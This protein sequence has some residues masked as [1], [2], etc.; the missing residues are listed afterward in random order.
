MHHTFLFSSEGVCPSDLLSL[1]KPPKPP[2]LRIP[3]PLA[4]APS[5]HL[6]IR[7]PSRIRRLRLPRIR[8]RKVRLGG[9]I[10]IAMLGTRAPTQA[11]HGHIAA[12]IARARQQ[13]ILALMA[14]PILALAAGREIALGAGH[15]AARVDGVEEQE[16]EQH[17]QGVERVLVDFLAGDGALEALRVFDQAEDDAHGDGGDDEVDDAEDRQRAPFLRRGRLAQETEVEFHDEEGEGEDEELLHPD[18]A[19]VDVDAAQDLVLREVGLRGAAGAPQLDQEG[20]DVQ[21]HEVEA[22]APGFDLGQARVR[23]EVEDHPAEDHVDVGVDP[24]RGDEQQDEVD[25]VGALGGR[26]LD[27]DHAEEVGARLP[28]GGHGDYPAVAFFVDDALG[29]VADEGEDEEHGED[30]G[31]GDV[32]AEVPDG[33]IVVVGHVAVRMGGIVD[34]HFGGGLSC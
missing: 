12:H 30:V 14:A 31:G 15:D 6:P 24:E 11:P 23:S 9:S 17:G 8:P 22:E 7:R 25:H 5:L 19:H 29:D 2:P 20:E 28:E 18:A 4:R 21:Q 1:P 33:A 34:C 10:A 13:A 3:L 32:G 26:V 16:R 27:A